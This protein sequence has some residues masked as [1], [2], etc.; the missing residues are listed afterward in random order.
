MAAADVVGHTWRSYGSGS[1]IL[2]LEARMPIGRTS[3][4]IDCVAHSPSVFAHVHR[5]AGSVYNVHCLALCSQPSWLQDPPLV[6]ILAKPGV[7]VIRS[8]VCAVPAHMLLL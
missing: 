8:E 6:R 1:N 5:S 7:P 4:Q 3:N 2:E